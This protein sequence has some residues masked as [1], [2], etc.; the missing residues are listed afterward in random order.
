MDKCT[1]CAKKMQ[2][3]GIDKCTVCAKRMQTNGIN[4]YPHRCPMTGKACSAIKTEFRFTKL[5]NRI[6]KNSRMINLDF[7]KR[8]AKRL[9]EQDIAGIDWKIEIKRFEYRMRYAM[10]PMRKSRA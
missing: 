5:P 8:L 6:M 9:V 1:A 2:T 7:L 3:N 4:S 10:S